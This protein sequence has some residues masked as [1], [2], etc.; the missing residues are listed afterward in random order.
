MLF[1]LFIIPPAGVCA[2]TPEKKGL[3]GE[4]EREGVKEIRFSSGNCFEIDGRRCGGG[5]DVSRQ[6]VER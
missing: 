1:I 5:V 4:G 3:E 6:V 2:K